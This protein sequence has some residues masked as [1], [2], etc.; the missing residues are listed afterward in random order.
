MSEHRWSKFWWAD[1]MRDPSLRSCSLAARGLWMDM[2]AI[3]F[4]GNPRGHVTIGRNGATPKQ[5]A[6][7]AGISERHCIAL[8]EELEQA[9][10]FS[11]TDAGVMFSRRMVRDHEAAEAGRQAV[12]KR[13]ANRDEPTSPP[14]TPPN[15]VHH[16]PPHS[17]EAEADTEADTETD[18]RVESAPRAASPRPQN[19]SRLP[20]D[21]WPSPDACQF[22]G[23]LGLDAGAVGAKFRDYWI[24]QPGAK[25]R[26]LDWDATFR[27][28][29]RRE[30]ENRKPA[31]PIKTS[32]WTVAEQNDRLVRMARSEPEPS[33][34]AIPSLRIAR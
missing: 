34:T 22:A 19:G 26:K 10:V 21:W 13:W 20:S 3:A 32:Q 17:L 29:C 7:I 18:K 12:A 1:W 24:A 4:D 33:F 31:Q 11:R 15:R 2:L 30:A 9:E 28:W 25:G 6:T 27:N 23:G 5:I 16:S 14:I 8:L